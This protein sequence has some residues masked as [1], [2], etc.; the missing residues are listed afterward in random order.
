MTRAV[1]FMIIAMRDNS[2]EKRAIPGKI[3]A[4]LIKG[5]KL[6]VYMKHG[7]CCGVIFWDGEK[8]RFSALTDLK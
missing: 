6:R 4:Q 2:K 8:L 5:E 7:S 1:F 3:L